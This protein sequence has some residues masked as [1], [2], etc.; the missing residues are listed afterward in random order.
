MKPH[1]S[2]ILVGVL[3]LAIG[4]F[5]GRE[6]LKYEIQ[7]AT[8]D[9]LSGIAGV[10]SGSSLKNKQSKRETD[11]EA[12]SYLPSLELYQ[13][14]GGYRKGELKCLR[15]PCPAVWGKIKNTGD[16]SLSRVTVAA[17][18]PDETG[19]PIFEETSL[20]VNS[21]SIFGNDTPLKPGYIRDFGYVVEDCP[22][23]CV[24]QEVKVAVVKL[25]FTE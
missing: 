19:N 7:S 14:R 21:S 13:V 6:H 11:E 10:F 5:A 17:Y 24:P 9:A 25:E 20:V 16:R 22:S 1:L 15:K 12:K 2:T 18:F 4:Y 23:E 3:S 8:K